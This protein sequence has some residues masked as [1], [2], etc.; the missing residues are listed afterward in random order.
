MHYRTDLTMRQ[1]AP[2]FEIPTATVCRIVRRPGPLLA[3][4][5]APR[6]APGVERLPIVNGTLV[7]CATAA[8]P[9]PAAHAWR[10]S[11]LP[12]TCVGTM[13][14][15]DSAFIDTGLAGPHRRRAG[16][17][18]PAGPGGGQCASREAKVY[19]IAL[20]PRSTDNLAGLEDTHPFIWILK[21]S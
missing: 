14:L 12:A 19:S 11:D 20:G 10:A 1:A 15:V 9:P 7:P 2:W 5:A 21:A 13:V 8:S 3:L 4:E 18:P 16:P 6:P 17:R